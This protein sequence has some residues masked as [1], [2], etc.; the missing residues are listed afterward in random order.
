MAMEDR[1]RNS[2]MIESE[3][4]SAGMRWPNHEDDRERVIG[5]IG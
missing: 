1:G 5:C 2:G 4:M 3:S